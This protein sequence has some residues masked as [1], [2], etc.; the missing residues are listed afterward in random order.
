LARCP[1]ADDAVLAL[2]GDVD[3]ADWSIE[4]VRALMT[5]RA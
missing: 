3:P 1:A 5:E 4:V 2:V